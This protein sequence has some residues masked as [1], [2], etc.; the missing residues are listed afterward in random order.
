MRIIYTD[1]M[2]SLREVFEPYEEGCHLVENA[3]KE[4]VE[5]RKKYYK[6]VNEECQK[7]SNIDLL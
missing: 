1:E 6:L 5:A 3:P 2:R 7:N 4:A